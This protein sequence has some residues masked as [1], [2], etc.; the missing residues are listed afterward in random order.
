MYAQ[1]AKRFESSAQTLVSS[2]L[3]FA[4]VEPTGRCI[5]EF[6]TMMKYAESQLPTANAY[7]VARCTRGDSR[8]QPKIQRP[9]NVDSSMKA[10]S[11]SMASGAPKT[12]PT[13]FE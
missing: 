9:R 1:T 3:P 13:N 2:A 7:A 5:H 4:T 10:A 11:P 8:S 6:A 12:S